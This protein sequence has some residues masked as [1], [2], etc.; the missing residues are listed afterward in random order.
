MIRT[1]KFSVLCNERST[2]S[3]APDNSVALSL[4]QGMG[5]VTRTQK[6]YDDFNFKFQHKT[7]TN[8]FNFNFPAWI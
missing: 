7:K 8:S 6:Q 5:R 3:E 1:V 4:F 2:V